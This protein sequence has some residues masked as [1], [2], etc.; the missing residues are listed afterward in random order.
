MGVFYDVRVHLAE[1]PQ[2]MD[3][4]A[5]VIRDIIMNNIFLMDHQKFLAHS[6]KT[7]EIKFTSIGET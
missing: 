5:P 4:R 7:L 2:D 1:F 6:S 3:L